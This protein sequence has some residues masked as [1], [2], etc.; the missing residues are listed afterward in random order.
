[1]GEEALELWRR[2]VEVGGYGTLLA[3]RYLAPNMAERGS[4]AIVNLTS[5]SSRLGMAG[6]SEY[7]AGKA[8][9]HKISNSLAQEL[10]PHGVRVNCVSPGAIWSD[11]LVDFYHALAK[12][13]GITYEKLLAEHTA[14]MPLRR[15]VT[16]DEVA[17]ACSS[18]PQIWR[19][20]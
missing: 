19:R 8:Q 1:M 5:M 6:R 10:G 18:W 16:N 20:G 15:I 9:T 12:E 4:G 7:A 3:C 11:T 2:I 17:N 13:R 14:A